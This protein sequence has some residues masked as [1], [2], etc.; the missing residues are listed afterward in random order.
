MLVKVYKASERL[1][2]AY[3]QTGAHKPDKTCEAGRV[4][5]SPR[6][7]AQRE[8]NLES[9]SLFFFVAQGIA[10][11]SHANLKDWIHI[12]CH[13]NTP[14][15][16]TVAQVIIPVLVEHPE[17]GDHVTLIKFPI[18]FLDLITFED[19]YLRVPLPAPRFFEGSEQW[20][21]HLLIL[22]I[23]VVHVVLAT[24]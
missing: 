17:L 2:S 3:A 11:Y 16:V 19:V 7:D 13:L 6:Q 12:L 15:I 8:R 23:V 1:V 18:S 5:T 24:K 21:L 22:R 9:E 10:N 20:R 14:A 4:V